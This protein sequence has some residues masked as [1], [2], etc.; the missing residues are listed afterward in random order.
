MSQ[1]NVVFFHIA[2]E[3]YGGGSQ[4]LYRLLSSIDRE[5]ISP[6]L[7][8][9]R[10][11]T[12]TRKLESEGVPVRIVPFRGS[13]DTYNQALLTGPTHLKVRAAARLPQFNLE[14]RDVFQGADVIWCKNL[15]ALLSAAPTILTS[16]ARTIWNIG[17][18]QPS[19]GFTKYLNR[20]GIS[21]ADEIL[22]ESEI[23]ASRIFTDRQ[24]ERAEDKLTIISKG[25]DVSRFE[26]G[27][28]DDGE[29]LRVGFAALLTPRKRPEDFIRAAA[30]VRDER[31]DVTFPIAGTPPEEGPEN[32]REQLEEL[33]DAHGL[34]DAVEF[35]GWV[36]EMSAYLDS[37]DVLVLPSLN[38]GIPGVVKEAMA[39]ET[40]VVATNVGGVPEI[41]EDGTTGYLVDPRSPPEIAA[42]VL[43]L[44]DGPESRARMG[45]AGRR[46]IVKDYSMETY[47]EQYEK[48]LGSS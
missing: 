39:T 42:A 41:V 37:L 12:L 5:S 34:S 40:P 35:V 27:S 17:L 18:G 16:S 15:R 46:R 11:D 43:K 32:Y 29:D 8:A 36:D 7:L 31:P 28:T 14:A 21:L 10:E 38:E 9:Q 25:I 48:I 47:I 20:I 26:P 2:S 22:I 1:T 45:A 13:L 4:M 44:L 30:L 6:V 24:L 23:Q 19:G 33:V 3:S